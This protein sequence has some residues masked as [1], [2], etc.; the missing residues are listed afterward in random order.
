MFEDSLVES[1][2]RIQGTQ[3]KWFAVGSKFFAQSGLLLLLILYPLLHPEALP[4]QS[5]ERLLIAPPPPRAPAPVEIH[6]AAAPASSH[7]A[8]SLQAQLQAPATIPTHISND[9]GEAPPPNSW[10]GIP[11]GDPAAIPAGIPLGSPTSINVVRPPAPQH[12]MKVSMGVATGQLLNPIR[13]IYPAIAKAARIQGTVVIEATISRQGTI[14]NLQVTEGPQ[15]LRQAA[16]DA[17][18]AARY[19]PFFLN[20]EPVDG[21]TSIQTMSSFSPWRV[22]GSAACYSAPAGISKRPKPGITVGLLGLWQGQV[23]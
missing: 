14:E 21:Q 6:H 16:I 2:G 5:I 8:L 3:S 20:G 22:D 7:P 13:P 1:Q 4:K 19:R 12:P 15:M 18:A 17:V 10:G 11:G 9:S 23:R